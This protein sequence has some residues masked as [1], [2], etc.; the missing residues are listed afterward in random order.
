M[1]E[2]SKFEHQLDPEGYYFSE[3]ESLPSEK[4]SAD[5]SGARTAISM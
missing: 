4:P 2:K 5:S 3:L 1:E